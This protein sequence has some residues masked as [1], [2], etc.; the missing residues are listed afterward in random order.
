MPLG[1]HTYHAYSISRHHNV[2]IGDYFL[3][4]F[5]GDHY[6]DDD[7][8]KK[9]KR[10][11]NRLTEKFGIAGWSLSWSPFN[12]KPY[13]PLSDLQKYKRMVTKTYNEHHKK[14]LQIIND[15]SL[16]VDDFLAE[17]Q[18]KVTN[19]IDELKKRYKQ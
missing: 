4:S 1:V 6:S 15:N 9:T 8:I 11:Q 7:F 18:K 2:N 3:G 16:F 17:E 14:V 10:L 13:T 19:R 5:V 12:E